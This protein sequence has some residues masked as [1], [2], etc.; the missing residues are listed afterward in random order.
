MKKITLTLS[1][2]AVIG[3]MANETAVQ[4]AEGQKAVAQEGVKYIKTLGKELKSNVTKWM[5]KDPTGLEAAYFCSKSAAR[6]TKEANAKFPEGVRVYRTA[7]KLR[8]TK[9]A[10]DA[11]D[12][13]VML[14]W[15]KAIEEGSFKK[16][17][18]VVS[19]DGKERVY[20]PLL[21]EKGCLKCHGPVA[22]IDPKVRELIEK[23]YPEDRAVGFKEGDLRGVIVA[24][25]PKKK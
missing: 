2:F 5:K 3:L 23:K 25:M 4:Q 7:L 8:N 12:K 15:E 17:P 9:N 16:K 22:K 20:V 14:K 1:L 13:E 11:T 6:L 19:V 10:P 18:M 21:V 24:E